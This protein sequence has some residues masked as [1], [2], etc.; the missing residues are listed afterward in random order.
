[1]KVLSGYPATTLFSASLLISQ[2]AQY[3]VGTSSNEQAS[4]AAPPVT[5]ALNGTI[6]LF[7]TS[8]QEH[9]EISMPHCSGSPQAVQAGATGSAGAAH[10]VIQ[11]SE[12]PIT[13]NPTGAAAP[14]VW[15]STGHPHCG[16]IAT[17]TPGV[18]HKLHPQPL[19]YPSPIITLF[20]VVPTL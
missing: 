15:Q 9:V 1:M 7:I 17:G 14:V 13:G 20:S 8:M 2:F 6:V 11:S 5:G 4:G 16:L 18:G 3:P 10:P 19:P 12:G